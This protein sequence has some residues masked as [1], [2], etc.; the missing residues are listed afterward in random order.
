M[1]E[2]VFARGYRLHAVTHGRGCVRHW[3]LRPMN[4]N[5]SAVGPA[6]LAKL[7]GGGGYCAG[8]NAYDTNDCHG[9]AAASGH[10]VVA[11]PRAVN[12]GCARDARYNRPERLRALDL[13]DSPLG[14]ACGQANAFGEALTRHRQRIE[15]AF[16]G[17]TMSGLGALPPFV[18]G[19][20]RVALWTA[21][22]IL[23]YMCACALRQGLM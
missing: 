21:A 23:Q 19:P 15:S 12:R 18:R 17:L 13:L 20:R 4:D 2:G 3:A 5:D 11:P 6:L 9:A 10:V 22:K 7:E 14:W 16:G 8:D 1:A